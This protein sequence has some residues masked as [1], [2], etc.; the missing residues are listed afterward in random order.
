MYQM[1]VDDGA[2]VIADI[3]EG[4]GGA[5]YE[6]GCDTSENRREQIELIGDRHAPGGSDHDRQ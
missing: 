3:V 5:M 6:Y 4:V 2:F 1:L